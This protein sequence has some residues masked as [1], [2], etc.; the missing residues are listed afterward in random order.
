M[1]AVTVQP[2]MCFKKEEVILILASSILFM[3]NTILNVKIG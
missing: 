3:K 1:I 2:S